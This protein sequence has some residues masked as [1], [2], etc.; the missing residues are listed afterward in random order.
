MTLRPLDGEPLPQLVAVA[1]QAAIEEAEALREAMSNFSQAP[2]PDCPAEL[3]QTA[4]SDE[5]VQNA[6]AQATVRFD[7]TRSA[8]ER[9]LT[10]PE[11]VLST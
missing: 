7:E 5:T 6:A 3:D 9:C 1:G 10:P 2:Q 11:L 8:A 4:W